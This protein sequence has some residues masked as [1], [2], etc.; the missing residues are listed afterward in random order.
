MWSKICY[1]AKEAER[2]VVALFAL[3][4][5]SL[6]HAFVMCCLMWLI[7]KHSLADS[8]GDGAGDVYIY[9]GV[10]DGGY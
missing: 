5:V 1:T 4:F 3:V 7:R 9:P 8:D 6:C 10:G 2:S